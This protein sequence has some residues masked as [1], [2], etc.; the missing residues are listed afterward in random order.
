[1]KSRIDRY[2]AVLGIKGGVT[3]EELKALYR[4]RA[5]RLHPDR[6]PH[7]TSHEQFVLL[8]EA[9]EFYKE[10]LEAETDNDSAKVFNSK[11]YPNH[12][13]TEK[14]NVERRQEARRKA[15]EKAKMKYRDFENKGYFKRL[16]KMYLALDVMRFILALVILMVLPVLS[17]LQ[18]GFK[19]LIVLLFIQFITYPLWS[20]AIKR[21]I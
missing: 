6:N 1:M 16:D 9:Y 15:S 7:P 8:H 10:L 20:R 3:S 5:K 18:E 13:Y 12:Y 21:F 14:W 11:K 4:D 19:G 2:N 17:Y